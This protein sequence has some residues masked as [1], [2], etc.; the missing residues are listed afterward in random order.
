M[1]EL[2]AVTAARDVIAGRLVRT[3]VLR[4]E[5]RAF[6]PY[7]DG[8]N[9][10]FK[11]EMFQRTG[12]FKIRGVLNKLHN[13]SAEEKQRGV[14]GLSSGNHAQALAYGARLEG[15]AATIVMPSFAPPNKVEATRAYGAKVEIVS[16]EELL[17]SFERIRD[18]RG[19]T[20]VHPFNDEHI[21]AG[22]GTAGLELLEEVPEVDAVLAGIGGGGWISGV[23]TAV[24]GLKPGCKVYGAEPEG[25]PVV[26]KSLDAGSAQKL[27]RV[28]TIADG[29]AAP[30]TGELVLDRIQRLVD[31]VVLVRDAEILEAL[32]AILEKVKAVV[33]P[34]GAA[35]FA[36]LL[37]GRVRFPEGSTVALMLSGGNVDAARLRDLLS[38]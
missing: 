25:A 21:V 23:A 15:L 14:I 13:L 24:K 19:L 36:A 37:S 28:A 34:S 26:R 8:L 7:L 6:S 29:L 18:E 38:S 3:P 9:L 2:E 22:A 33:E 4:L 32:K 17:S 16:A 20:P 35:C 31:N 5:G 1:T 11:L 30:F 12:S 10:V 27:D